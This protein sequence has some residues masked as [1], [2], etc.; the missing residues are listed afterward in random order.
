VRLAG[1]AAVTV[2]PPWTV[3]ACPLT[4][5]NGG[6]CATASWILGSVRVT[7]VGLPLVVQGGTAICAPTAAPLSVV[8]T[9]ARVR[10]S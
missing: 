6:P 2:P 4:P 5:A 1:S 7:S 9:Q 3:T 10:A 8:L